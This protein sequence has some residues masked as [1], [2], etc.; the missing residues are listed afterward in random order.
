MPAPA[1][2]E[3]AWD[4]VARVIAVG[5]VHGDYDQ[6]LAVLRAAD[7]VDEE[8]RWIGGRTHLVQTGDRV[9]RGP[10]SRK[11]MDLFMRLEKE[12]KKAGGAVHALI[13]NHELMNV[14]GDL[15][16]TT[17][18][19]LAAFRTADS[20]KVRDQAWER[21]WRARKDRGEPEP[22]EADRARWEERHPLGQI[23]HRRAFGPDGDY[24]RWLARANAVIRIGD[25]LF[26]HGGLSPKY[27]DF[28]LRDLNDR[29]RA[30]LRAGDADGA[31]VATDPEGPLWFRGLA[32]GDPG[33]AAV[34]EAILQKHGCR[35][36][37]IG[38]TPTDGL[39][40]PRYGGRVLAIDVGLSRA[41]GGP[42]AALLIE[43]GVAFA[44][45]RGQR[46]AL[47]TEG[48]EPLLAYFR[49]VGALEPDGGTHLQSVTERLIGPVT[50]G[51]PS[52][53]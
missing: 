41:Y 6:L 23:E 3:D 30:E 36:L 29:I 27:A 10:D 46:L 34:L 43:N 48:G 33:L 14:I 11:V 17:A 35:R 8:A 18:E 26:L 13:G 47:P 37:V 16:Y 53:R 32:N 25:T 31:V 22:T 52:S 40:L 44:L 9:D 24:G 38:H 7:L 50:A 2:A 19:E 5:D 42:P 15:R 12:A 45:H 51:S 20:E 39:V 21:R 4:G 1:R 28:A 49:A